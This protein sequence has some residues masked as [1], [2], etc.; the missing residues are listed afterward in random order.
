MAVDTTLAWSADCGW[1]GRGYLILR[2]H[3]HRG[4]GERSEDCQ[5]CQS[6]G[7]GY[8]EIS[9]PAKLVK[10]KIR[11]VIKFRIFMFANFKICLTNEFT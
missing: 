5:Y 7:D 11:R 8:S 1:T 2:P 6:S 4:H 9:A 3:H 10:T